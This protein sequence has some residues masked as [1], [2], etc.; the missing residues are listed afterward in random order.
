[1]TDDGSGWE[2]DLSFLGSG[3]RFRRITPGQYGRHRS[4]HHKDCEGRAWLSLG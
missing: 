2:I 3:F 4:L 1:M